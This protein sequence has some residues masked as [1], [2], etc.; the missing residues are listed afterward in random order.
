ML[1]PGHTLNEILLLTSLSSRGIA[2]LRLMCTGAPDDPF[3]CDVDPPTFGQGTILAADKE[4]CTI[5][6]QLME[7]YMLKDKP[8][9]IEVFTPEAVMLPHLQDEPSEYTDLGAPRCTLN[10]S[11]LIIMRIAWRETG[12][13]GRVY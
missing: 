3:L 6:F 5:D 4:A 12:K 13:W 7:G 2:E 1:M 9:R 11:S 8:Y 10:C